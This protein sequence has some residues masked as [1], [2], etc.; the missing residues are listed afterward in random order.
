MKNMNQIHHQLKND[1]D[2]NSEEVLDILE[3]TYSEGLEFLNSLHNNG[4]NLQFISEDIMKIGNYIATL[5]TALSMAESILEN[6][7]S[8]FDK[9][10]FKEDLAYY[11]LSSKSSTTH[12]INLRGHDENYR[13][14]QVA[15]GLKRLY[16]DL[17]TKF[18]CLQFV[19]SNLKFEIEKG[20]AVY[21][22]NRTI[23]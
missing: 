13:Y 12:Q 1:E 10:L 11:K 20:L 23:K 19:G 22:I 16:D 18:K 15:K 7:L 17:N 2:I 4:E 5:G 21:T 9:K 14:N 6:K 8:H 3:D